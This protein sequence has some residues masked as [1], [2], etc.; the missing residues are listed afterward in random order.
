MK[1]YV[2]F[3]VFIALIGFGAFLFLQKSNSLKISSENS[4]YSAE[5]TNTT[6]SEN[7]NKSYDK[8]ENTQKKDVTEVSKGE[9]TNI[10]TEEELAS[11]S[12]NIYSKDNARQNN[13][14]IT[15]NR[16]NGTIVKNGEIFSFCQTLGPST[17]N[18]GYQEADIFDKNGN[19]KKGLGGRKLPN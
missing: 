14:S 2:F 9:T 10:P 19:K 13:I 12:T 15:C 4:S 8:E 6:I 3:I 16:L 5:K 17:S 7:E 1:K 18:K 11:F